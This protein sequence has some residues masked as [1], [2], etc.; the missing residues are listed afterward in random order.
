MKPVLNGTDYKSVLYGVIVKFLERF[1]TGFYILFFLGVV[2]AC[3]F[4]CFPS[5]LSI[6]ALTH[7][8]AFTRNGVLATAKIPSRWTT[9]VKDCYPV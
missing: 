2:S 1:S 6:I 4:S 3:F 9:L 5:L 7:N 8:L